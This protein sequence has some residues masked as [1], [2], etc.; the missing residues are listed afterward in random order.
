MKGLKVY[1]LCRGLSGRCLE[2][3]RCP[4]VLYFHF[5]LMSWRPC[6]K[7]WRFP[8]PH[9]P[10]YQPSAAAVDLP[11][12]VDLFL[13]LVRTQF[14]LPEGRSRGSCYYNAIVPHI[15]HKYEIVRNLV[16]RCDQRSWR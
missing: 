4:A 1:H 13:C 16:V 6:P 11:F 9:L 15:A 5:H 7:T 2:H 10:I 14:L 3:F 8:N 12:F